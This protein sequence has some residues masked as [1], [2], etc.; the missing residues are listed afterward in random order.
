VITY[1]DTILNGPRWLKGWPNIYRLLT[2]IGVC[3]DAIG[4]AAM[5]AVVMR[6]PGVYDGQSLPLL[7]QHRQIPRGPGESD[8]SYAAR[9]RRFRDVQRFKGHPRILL[10]M[11]QG[12]FLPSAPVVRVV[13]NDGGVLALD[14]SGNYTAET[15]LAWDWDGNT[16]AVSRFWVI[17]DNASVGLTPGAPLWDDDSGRRWDRPLRLWDFQWSPWPGL[18]VD[19]VEQFRAPNAFCDSVILV[20]DWTTFLANL[21]DGDWDDW[22]NRSTAA[23][24]ISCT[25]LCDA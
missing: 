6:W 16:A 25:E 11:V 9:L 17:L 12:L 19:V 23:Y 22:D 7:G 8:A 2:T 24:Y 20:D 21:P 4:D 5:A 1:R 15:P 10:E 18:L 14:A 13:A 3:F